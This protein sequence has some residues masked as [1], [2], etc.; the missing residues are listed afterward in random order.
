[1]YTQIC[2]LVRKIFSCPVRDIYTQIHTNIHP[3]THPIH[4]TW[5]YVHIHAH[6]QTVYAHKH[7]FLQ[8]FLV[9]RRTYLWNATESGFKTKTWDARATRFMHLTH[10]DSPVRI[11]VSS[12]FLV[13]DIYQ[14][15]P[16]LQIFHIQQEEGCLVRKYDYLLSSV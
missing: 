9:S 12:V 13:G 4:N 5:T 16:I 2:F 10:T 8:A 14:N 7:G 15:C 3:G 1:M 11:S 6:I